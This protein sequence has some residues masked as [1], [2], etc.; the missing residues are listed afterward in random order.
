MYICYLYCKPHIFKKHI[1]YI[2]SLRDIL[3]LEIH[4]VNVQFLEVHV[5]TINYG[6]VYRLHN[7]SKGL[8]IVILTSIANTLLDTSRHSTKPHTAFGVFINV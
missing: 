4:E 6:K 5:V 3:R 8:G 2:K 7:L 1:H